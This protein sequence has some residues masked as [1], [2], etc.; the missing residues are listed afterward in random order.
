MIKNIT[1]K[2]K[3]D[4]ISTVD[5]LSKIRK[6]EKFELTKNIYQNKNGMYITKFKKGKK[7]DEFIARIYIKQIIITKD[8]LELFEPV[9]SIKYYDVLYD[10]DKSIEDVTFEE[11]IKKLEAERLFVYDTKAIKKLINEIFI[12]CHNKEI[13][14][15]DFIQTETRVFKEGFFLKDGKVIENTLIN[16]LETSEE[17][18]KESIKL[19][20]DLLNTRG[21]AIDND[22]TLLRFM[23]WSPFSWCLK[24]IGKTKGLYGLILTGSPKTNT[25]WKLLKLLLDILHTTR[26]RKSSI[27]H[28]SIWKQI[29]REYTSSYYR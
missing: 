25:N 29:R 8:T 12:H 7:E 9:Y 27:N 2:D 24:E 3:K 26:Q 15:K 14:G 4:K 22:C 20:N 11:L 19:I 28:I 23:L 16:G 17:Q 6:Y 1:S 13:K 10:A 5:K 18:V 21:S